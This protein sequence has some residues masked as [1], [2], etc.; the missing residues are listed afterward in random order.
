MRSLADFVTAFVC[1]NEYRFLIGCD[2]SLRGYL[3]GLQV[4]YNRETVFT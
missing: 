4:L 3:S 2:L 1:G